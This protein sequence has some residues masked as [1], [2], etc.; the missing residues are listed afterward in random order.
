[1]CKQRGHKAETAQCP[2]YCNEQDIICFKGQDCIFSNMYLCEPGVIY[3]GNLFNCSETAYQWKKALDMGHPD[4]AAR[5]L[6][7]RNGFEAKSVAKELDPKSVDMWKQTRGVSVMEKVLEAKF[8]H[9]VEFQDEL[10]DSGN[11]YLAEVTYNRFWAV[12]LSEEKAVKCKPEYFPGENVLGKLLMRLRSKHFSNNNNNSD[13]KYWNLVLPNKDYYNI[14]YV[15]LVVCSY[16]LL[17]AFHKCFI[18]NI[19]VP[20]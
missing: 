14:S 9:V 16:I 13:Q 6:E 1:M 18:C 8:E 2:A 3:E 4:V 20:I 12:G 17:S 5:I 19:Y 11:A 10:L 15:G 7:S